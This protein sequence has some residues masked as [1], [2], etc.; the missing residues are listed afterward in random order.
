MLLDPGA[1]EPLPMSGIVLY[2]AGSE[3]KRPEAKGLGGAAGGALVVAL[4]LGA[5]EETSTVGSD[6]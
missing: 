4:V 2:R 1:S 6:G 3:G 5:V